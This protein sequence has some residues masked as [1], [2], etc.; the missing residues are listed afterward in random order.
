MSSRSGRS[1][2]DVNRE[3][4]KAEAATPAAASSPESSVDV[5]NDKKKKVINNPSL[6]SFHSFLLRSILVWFIVLS[7]F[8]SFVSLKSRLIP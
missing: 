8:E 3:M 7:F 1:R 4:T 2:P 6:L 5:K